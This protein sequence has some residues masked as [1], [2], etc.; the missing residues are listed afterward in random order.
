M[1]SSARRI[2]EQE[3]FARAKSVAITGAKNKTIRIGRL[4]MRRSSVFLTYVLKEQIAG[5]AQGH[6]VT[7]EEDLATL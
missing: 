3:L 1:R 4:K 2:A 5:H 7:R 6:D